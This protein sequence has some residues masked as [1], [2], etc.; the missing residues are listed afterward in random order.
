[1][2][3]TEAPIQQGRF[4]APLREFIA[5]QHA[6]AALLLAATCIALAWANSPW[7]GSYERLW[8]MTLAVEAGDAAFSLDLRHW[9]NDGL[10]ALF[11]FVAG[12]EIRREF[13]MGD[14]RERRRIATPVIAA[15]G[16]MVV[17][18]LLYL[19]FNFGSTAHGAGASRWGPTRRSRWESSRSSEGL[20]RRAS[21]RSC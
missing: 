5:T 16:G 13:D 11:F 18:A 19:A 7:A 8:G 10:M 21:G 15:I 6:G 20:P 17:P 2:S 4:T 3:T 9:I 12:L 1:M 14:L